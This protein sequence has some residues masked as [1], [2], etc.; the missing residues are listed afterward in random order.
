MYIGLPQV[1]KVRNG[2]TRV[3]LSSSNGLSYQTNFK[4]KLTCNAKPV[5][6]F[7][8]QS[9]ESKRRFCS[10]R[11]CS[12]V[13]DARRLAEQRSIFE[14]VPHAR[15]QDNRAPI[16]VSLL[17]PPF[18]YFP[19]TLLSSRSRDFYHP[20]PPPPPFFFPRQQAERREKNDL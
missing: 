3:F 14:A 7:N 9:T 20:P 2:Q 1:V 4:L 13:G 18:F 5:V 17:P 19:S 6:I 16:R 10:S 8:P 15:A 11:F 12:S